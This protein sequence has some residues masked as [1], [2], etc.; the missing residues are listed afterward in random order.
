[1]DSQSAMA[2][3]KNPQFHNHTKHIDAKCHFLRRKVEEEVIELEYVPT[4]EQV[5]NTL[6]K[7]LN[8]EKHSKFAREMAVGWSP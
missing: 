4:G 1:M 5:A 2:I 6:T 7:A 8:R 3:A